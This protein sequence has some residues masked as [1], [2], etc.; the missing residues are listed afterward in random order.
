MFNAT[1]NSARVTSATQIR[2]CHQ[3]QDLFVNS[4]CMPH[5]WWSDY[6]NNANGYFGCETTRDADNITGFS[7]SSRTFPQKKTR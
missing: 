5:L 3:L 7:K 2:A 4:F 6:I 1:A